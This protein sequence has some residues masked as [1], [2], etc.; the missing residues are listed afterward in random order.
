[1]EVLPSEMI[2]NIDKKVISD[3]ILIKAV[4]VILRSLTTTS[5][6]ARIGK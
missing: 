1:M 2:K 4:V 6:Y 3:P 5:I